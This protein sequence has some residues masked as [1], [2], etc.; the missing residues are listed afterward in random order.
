MFLN[1]SASRA[2]GTESLQ[3]SVPRWGV[4][5]TGPVYRDCYGRLRKD[6]IVPNH[7]LMIHRYRQLDIIVDLAATV[8]VPWSQ[9]TMVCSTVT[10]TCTHDQLS[11]ADYPSSI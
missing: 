10:G 7:N 3:L 1:D 5:C 9:C 2:S 4:P 6:F 8:G 11:P